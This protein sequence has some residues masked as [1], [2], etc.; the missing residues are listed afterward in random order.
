[1]KKNHCAVVL[2]GYVN[3]YAI[4]RELREKKIENII[5]I[6]TGKNLASYSNLITRF[7]LIDDT[8][9]SLNRALQQLKNE[10]DKIILYPTHDQHLINLYKI[11]QKIEEFCYIPF[12]TEN[13]MNCLDK[14]YQYSWCQKLGIP[15]PKT[16]YISNSMDIDN[17]LAIQFPVLLK[18]T[19]RDDLK[20]DIFRNLVLNNKSDF[21]ALKD[22]I[23][24]YLEH[25]FSFLASEIIPGDGSNIFAYVGYRSKKG[26]IL[27]E[28]IGKKLAQYPNEFGVFASASNQAP[29]IIRHQGRAL[30]NG[31]NIMGIAEP[32]FK[33][34]SRDG[35][36]KLMEINLRSMMWHRVGNLSGVNLQYTQ[37]LDSLGMKTEMQPQNTTRDIHFVYMKH[38]LYNLFFRDYYI[39]TFI[40]N[41][42]KSDE[43][44]FAVFNLK[45]ILPIFIDVKN[46]TRDALLSS[47]LPIIDV[48][49]KGKK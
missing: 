31:M 9:D 10:Y 29:E 19:N 4:I 34:D 27:N 26:M 30:L 25:G 11:H 43:T 6:D 20:K 37:Y 2:G 35:C 40:N 24:Y 13:F 36:Y 39:R 28:W 1:M 47:L 32:E 46:S 41:V 5:L 44:H 33:F 18:P 23:K 3:G 21:N 48:R 45:D 8:A 16:V 14:N 49:T 15:C 38:E 22:K 7:F 12:N 42:F 17:I